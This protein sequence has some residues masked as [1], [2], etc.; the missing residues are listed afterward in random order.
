MN[1]VHRL[2]DRRAR[3]DAREKAQLVE[4]EPQSASHG[5]VQSVA[6]SPREML[7]ESVE[8]QLPTQY[9]ER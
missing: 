8:P 7:D 1:E 4:S 3:R 9:A 6:P 2:V 5:R